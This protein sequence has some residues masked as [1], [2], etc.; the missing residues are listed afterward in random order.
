MDLFPFSDD[1]ILNCCLD[2]DWQTGDTY[3]KFLLVQSLNVFSRTLSMLDSL[4]RALNLKLKDQNKQ[5]SNT[6]CKSN[7]TE[8][9][10]VLLKQL[11]MCRLS[12]RPIMNTKN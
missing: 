3:L 11:R 5:I 8:L 4:K 2:G 6:S 9:V 12:G 1:V 7:S 10:F